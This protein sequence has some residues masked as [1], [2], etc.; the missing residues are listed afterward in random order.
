[1][2]GTATNPEICFIV[3]ENLLFSLFDDQRS[4]NKTIVPQQLRITA[5]LTKKTLELCWC[6]IH[7]ENTYSEDN[8]FKRPRTLAK[9]KIDAN[10]SSNHRETI[11]I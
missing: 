5:D 10:E 6:Q 2:K 11:G 7:R 4:S 8:E 1:M 3:I 9:H